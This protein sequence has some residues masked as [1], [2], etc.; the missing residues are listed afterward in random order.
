MAGWSSRTAAT[1]TESSEALGRP[2]PSG[3]ASGPEPEAQALLPS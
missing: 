2:A 1:P 3:S